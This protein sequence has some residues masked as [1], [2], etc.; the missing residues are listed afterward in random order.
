M[1]WEG[2]ERCWEVLTP[3]NKSPS[4]RAN[5]RLARENFLRR[6]WRQKINFRDHKNWKNTRS[7]VL[8]RK[9]CYFTFLTPHPTLKVKDYL[10]SAV[11]TTYSIYLQ[12]SPHLKAVCSTRNLRTVHAVVIRWWLQ[13]TFTTVTHI[14]TFQNIFRRTEKFSNFVGTSPMIVLILTMLFQ[15]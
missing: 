15:P 7:G 9:C 14:K 4:W 3:S 5:I 1:L 13:I 10:L 6:L 2:S 8:F 12:L 11:R